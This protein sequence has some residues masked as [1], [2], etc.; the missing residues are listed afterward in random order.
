MLA[1]AMGITIFNKGIQFLLKSLFLALGVDLG[2]A[3]VLAWYKIVKARFYTSAYKS[4][5]T[6][7]DGRKS[8]KRSKLKGQDAF[9]CK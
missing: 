5:E 3:A 9:T 8:L 2:K 7:K 6:K 1:V 4:L